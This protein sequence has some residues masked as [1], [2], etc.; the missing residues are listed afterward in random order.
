MT[1]QTVGE[2]LRTIHFAGQLFL[3]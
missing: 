1:I 3:S 2:S